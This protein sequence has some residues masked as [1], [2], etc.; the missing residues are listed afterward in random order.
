M[1]TYLDSS[2]RPNA[3][4]Q[5]RARTAGRDKPCMRDMLIAR[6]LHALVIS[7][8]D[9]IIQPPPRPFGCL[10]QLRVRRWL[11]R[12]RISPRRSEITLAFSCGARSAFK[13]KE[14]SYLRSMLSRR[15]LQGFV[16]CRLHQWGTASRCAASPEYS[17]NSFHA[18]RIDPRCQLRLQESQT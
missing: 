17:N 18:G 5:R 1:H 9:L 16:R 7:P 14:T 10:I 4:H 15:Q 2:Q 8:H 13:L 6:P 11:R 3:G 12:F